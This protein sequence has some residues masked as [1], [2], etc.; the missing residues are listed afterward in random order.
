MQ[1][2]MG[3]KET[4]KE[5]PVVLLNTQAQAFTKPMAIGTLIDYS[6]ELTSQTEKM[7]AKSD[8]DLE[9]ENLLF[10]L[11]NKILHDI[12]LEKR[13]EMADFLRK[14]LHNANI[15]LDA[16][17]AAEETK[18]KPR[19]EQEKFESMAMKNPDIWKLKDALGLDLL[20]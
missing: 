2:V 12:F 1:D 17:I 5:K 14:K 20:F 19:T 3:S 10:K 18:A 13:Q 8:F 4:E 9:K 6:N 7:M 11:S 16:Y 15:Q